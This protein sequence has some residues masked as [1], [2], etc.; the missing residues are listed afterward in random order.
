[1]PYLARDVA[2]TEELPLD[3]KQEVIIRAGYEA[4]RVAQESMTPI[5]H[6]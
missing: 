2:L 6:I 3:R 1:M 4:S 5:S